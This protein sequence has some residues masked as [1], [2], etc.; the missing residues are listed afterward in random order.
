MAVDAALPA[1]PGFGA[2]TAKLGAGSIAA[3]PHPDAAE[4]QLAV[5]GSGAAGGH[6]RPIAL[7]LLQMGA[8]AGLGGAGGRHHRGG[9]AVAPEGY[10]TLGNTWGRAGPGCGGG[11]AHQPT[12]LLDA[13]GSSHLKWTKPIHDLHEF[14]EGLE[15][16][17]TVLPC[18]LTVLSG[19]RE[20]Q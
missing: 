15:P 17:Q 4:N 16:S 9:G 18:L 13:A 20:D 2:S 14:G 7:L 8:R 6:D 1:G 10:V 3:P 11:A 19:F 12:F 5:L